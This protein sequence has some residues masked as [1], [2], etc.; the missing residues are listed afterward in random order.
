MTSPEH[1]GTVKCRPIDYWDLG[2]SKK[3]GDILRPE[4]AISIQGRI[5]TGYPN[6]YC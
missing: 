5:S 3:V 4:I 1:R 6:S 2:N